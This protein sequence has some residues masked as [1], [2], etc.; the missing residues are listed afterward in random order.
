[1]MLIFSFPAPTLP[2]PL[3]NC[4]F[5]QDPS[6]SQQDVLM[7]VCSPVRP[8][9]TVCDCLYLKVATV[10]S[11]PRPAERLLHKI[12]SAS[13]A[14]FLWRC[15]MLSGVSSAGHVCCQSYT[16]PR[17][18]PASKVLQC[19]HSSHQLFLFSKTR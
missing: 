6:V 2:S 3:V 13:R 1:M 10:L 9:M 19:A 12:V 15:W 17:L 7:R 8:L 14:S 5:L 11:V 16:T 4:V 18:P